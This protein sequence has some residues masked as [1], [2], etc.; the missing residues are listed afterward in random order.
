MSWL[1]T[2]YDC[3]TLGDRDC[4][5]SSK[6][7]SWHTYQFQSTQVGSC[8]SFLI[9]AVESN[10]LDWWIGNSRCVARSD[11]ISRNQDGVW[12]DMFAIMWSKERGENLVFENC[13][14][15]N[16][17]WPSMR[18]SPVFNFIWKIESLLISTV[19]FR[20]VLIWYLLNWIPRSVQPQGAPL[21]L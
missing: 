1:W 21:W 6:C 15:A 14:T 11:L 9:S 2:C 5:D 16:P 12:L 13:P 17:F 3:N 10:I 18:S 8:A 20:H 4:S 7:V 19:S